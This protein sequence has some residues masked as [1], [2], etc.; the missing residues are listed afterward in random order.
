[1]VMH[2]NQISWRFYSSVKV[3]PKEKLKG[4]KSPKLLKTILRICLNFVWE[5]ML[6]FDLEYE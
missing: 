5:I 1:V 2:S 6:V 3:L 4:T